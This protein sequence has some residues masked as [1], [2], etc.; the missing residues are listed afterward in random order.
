MNMKKLILPLLLLARMAF[1]QGYAL[2]NFSNGTSGAAPSTTTLGNSLYGY[3]GSGTSWSVTNPGSALVYSTPS[4]SCASLPNNSGGTQAFT[5]NTSANASTGSANYAQFYFPSSTYT[6]GLLTA[7]MCYNGNATDTFSNSWDSLNVFSSGAGGGAS[8]L[9]VGDGSGNTVCSKT[10]SNIAFANAYWYGTGSSMTIGLEGS[11]ACNV[12][13]GT[14][15]Q[16]AVMYSNSAFLGYYYFGDGNADTKP[17]GHQ[18]YWMNMKMTYIGA[19]AGQF[20]VK[21]YPVN[22]WDGIL[23]PYRGI[24]WTQAGFPGDTPLDSSWPNCTSAQ[25]GTTVPIPCSITN[26]STITSA[27]SSCASANPSGSVLQLASGTFNVSGQILYP[28]AAHV[29]ARGQGANNTFI[30][31]NGSGSTNCR[32]VTG[33]VCFLGS[34]TS[35]VGNGTAR[36]TLSGTL[37]HG[38]TSV[39]LTQLSS[40]SAP[41][42]VVIGSILLFDACD[43][44][45]SGNPCSGTTIDNSN[46][47]RCSAIYTATP[48]G[49]SS[50]G[51]EPGQTLRNTEELHTVTAITGGT[52]GSSTCTVT[53]TPPIQNAEFASLNNPQAQVFQP[54]VEDGLENLTLDLSASG[55]PADAVQMVN[56]YDCWVTGVEIKKPTQVAIDILQGTNNL[57]ESNYIYDTTGGGQCASPCGIRPQ[58][59]GNNLIANNICQQVEQCIF[60][61][62][63]TTGNVLEANLCVGSSIPAAGSSD[64][65][66]CIDYHAG[67]DYDLAESNIVNQISCDDVHGTC[68]HQTSY[69]NFLTGWDSVPSNPVTVYTNA[70]ENFAFARYF[71]NIAGV[72]GTSGYHTHYSGTNEGNNYVLNWG[73]ALTTNTSVS[74]PA[75]PLGLSTSVRWGSYDSV[76]AAVRWCGTSLDT[77]WSATCGSTTEAANTASTYPGF[78]PVAGDTAIG[79]AVL[80]PSFFYTSRPSW[81]SSSIPFPAIGPDVSGG[82][83]GQCSGSLNTVGQFNGVA[84]LSNTQCGNHGITSSAWGGHLNAIP[85]MQCYLNIM[86]GPPDGSGGALIFNPSTCYTASASGPP[87]GLTVLGIG[88]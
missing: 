65:L 74:I 80:P 61:D 38:S 51:G 57:V 19:G 64:L 48:S 78:V 10:S 84:A 13:V 42:D 54:T 14:W 86:G 30:V 3:L 58:Y 7:W 21:E 36:A 46:D 37:T 52:C 6:L 76:T 33:M 56:C 83:V 35:I 73:Q 24:D 12:S 44:G 1:G 67:N 68:D 55:T 39:T 77:G 87:H 18:L 5:Y 71:N 66:N 2:E 43:S 8:T 62:G 16:V 60:F 25:A 63:D 32:S 79:E 41:A 31:H 81:W 29:V 17:S 28:T 26:L 70:I 69:R 49:C 15:Y 11:S 88:N 85:A 20:P 72:S 34:D 23:T 9:W 27:L 4:G 75:D 47:Y 59:T 53:I 82:N 50:D 40:G 22:P 45:T